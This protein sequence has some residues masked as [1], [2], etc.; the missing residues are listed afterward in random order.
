[1][2]SIVIQQDN[3]TIQTFLPLPMEIDLFN[4]QKEKKQPGKATELLA[5][6]IYNYLSGR[7]KEEI[8]AKELTTEF[9]ESPPS[10]RIYDILNV[11]EGL[12]LVSKCNVGKYSW[13]GRED[14]MIPTLRQLRNH[15]NSHNLV[16]IF[17]DPSTTTTAHN[18]QG[19]AK[20][21]L[22]FLAAK[23]MML[24]LILDP[25]EGLS[26]ADFLKFIFQNVSEKTKN[27]AAQRIG[28]VL[29]IFEVLKLIQGED[30][31]C[32]PTS[33]KYVGPFLD[34]A[35][36]ILVPVNDG[37]DTSDIVDTEV[38]DNQFASQSQSVA[39]AD[40]VDEGDQAPKSLKTNIPE[41]LPET[42]ACGD[43][44]VKDEVM[45]ER[46]QDILGQLTIQ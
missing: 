18:V 26:K 19:E 24:L 3:K 4:I 45:D 44:F 16:S 25:S 28:R 21:S 5:A 31:M 34:M 35:E 20:C 11:F 9:G 37:Q 22:Q 8:S 27:S 2:S 29:K 39:D 36:V 23:M 7:V 13:A 10:P 32:E 40:I 30:E 46:M 14:G 43:Y 41:L 1:M 6:E 33:H 17:L 12:G 42:F 15:G 38:L